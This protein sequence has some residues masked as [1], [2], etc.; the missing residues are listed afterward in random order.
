MNVII[1]F[2]L[3]FLLCR[4]ALCNEIDSCPH[5]AYSLGKLIWNTDDADEI[6][7]HAGLPNPDSPSF[8]TE[9]VFCQRNKVFFSYKGNATFIGMY[10]LADVS[11]KMVTLW[12]S[13]NGSYFVRIFGYLDKKIKLLLDRPSFALPE[14]IYF[15]S[16]EKEG[17]PS[18]IISKRINAKTEPARLMFAE[19]FSWAGNAYKSD[20]L[21]EWDKRLNL[22]P[23]LDAMQ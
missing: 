21:V 10:P 16:L 15:S 2:L 13:A 12:I 9:L 5:P 4:G 14:L 1:I 18:I 23:K 8:E 6:V 11:Q 19:I 3:Y 22:A 20:G 17:E 7:V